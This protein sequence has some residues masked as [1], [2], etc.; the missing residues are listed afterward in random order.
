MKMN[1]IKIENFEFPFY[2]FNLSQ[3]L[4]DCMDVVYTEEIENNP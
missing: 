3:I 4:Q 2:G 1:D